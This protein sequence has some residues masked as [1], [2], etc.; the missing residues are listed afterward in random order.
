MFQHHIR[1][2]RSLGPDLEWME[3]VLVLVT[4]GLSGIVAAFVVSALAWRTSIGE[5]EVTV[6]DSD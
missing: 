6:G 5:G 3:D 2:A 4:I 1:R